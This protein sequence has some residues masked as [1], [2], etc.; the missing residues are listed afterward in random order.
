MVWL[1]RKGMNRLRSGVW[2]RTMTLPL[3]YDGMANRG[4]GADVHFPK[5]A[6]VYPQ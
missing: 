3:C 4:D 6:G 1:R 2:R 5:T